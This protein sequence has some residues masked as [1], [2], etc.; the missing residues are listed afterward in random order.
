MLSPSAI[1]SS[2]RLRPNMPVRRPHPATVTEVTRPMRDSHR[3]CPRQ[4]YIRLAVQ[5]AL[6]SQMD[7]DHGGGTGGLNRE[8]GSLQIQLVRDP[9]TEKV[10]VRIDQSRNVVLNKV[11]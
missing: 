5:K 4:R 11:A 8:A 3:Y 2:R 10:L 9:G 7:R 6:A 1:A